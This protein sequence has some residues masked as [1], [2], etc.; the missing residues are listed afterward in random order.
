VMEVTCCPREDAQAAMCANG[1]VFRRAGGSAP[2]IRCGLGSAWLLRVPCHESN[3]VGG[4]THFA[5]WTGS[6]AAT[7]RRR[8]PSYPRRARWRALLPAALGGEGGRAVWSHRS[9]CQRSRAMRRPPRAARR[10]GRRRKQ[11]PPTW[12]GCARWAS[13]RQT[14]ARRWRR[15]ARTSRSA[16]PLDFASLE[17]ALHRQIPVDATQ[18]FGGGELPPARASVRGCDGPQRA[19]R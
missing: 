12:T 9:R 11:A 5:Q 17:H 2:A 19:S 15:S 8:C 4:L 7:R 6:C 1:G 14:A 10:P 18:M 3:Q 16:A 13:R